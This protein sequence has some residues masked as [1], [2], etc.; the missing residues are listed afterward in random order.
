MYTSDEAILLTDLLLALKDV[1]APQSDGF[2]GF[3]RFIVF[4]DD[5]LECVGFSGESSGGCEIGLDDG[6]GF[7]CAVRVVAVAV[8]GGERVLGRKGEGRS[9]RRE[10]RFAAVPPP[11]IASCRCCTRLGRLSLSPVAFPPS[12]AIIIPPFS[13]ISPVSRFAST[14]IVATAFATVPTL[15]LVESSRIARR[16]RGTSFWRSG[17]PALSPALR[18]WRSTSS[19]GELVQARRHARIRSIWSKTKEKDSLSPPFCN[20]TGRELDRTPRMSTPLPSLLRRSL[21][22]HSPSPSAYSTVPATQLQHERTASSAGSDRDQLIDSL[23]ANTDD[24][25]AS[26]FHS[27]ATSLDE[28]PQSTPSLPLAAPEH[29]HDQQ[30][31]DRENR[32]ENAADAREIL[33]KQLD[34]TR[35][36][37]TRTKPLPIRSRRRDAQSVI[38]VRRRTQRINRRR[39]IINFRSVAFSLTAFKS[40]C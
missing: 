3:R 1:K 11:P 28:L 22:R 9:S 29:H 21:D 16:R 27:R 15:L 4:E 34:N 13:V 5:S 38:S 39:R 30:D 10:I 26:S 14:T 24:D 32:T 12:S 36:L 20:R 6:D 18:R 17:P 33:R 40:S 37:K 7:R 35:L 25:D 8:L 2:A 19:R 31:I 23:I